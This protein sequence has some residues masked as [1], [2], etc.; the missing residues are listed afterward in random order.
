[1]KI[2]SMND[3]AREVFIL[4]IAVVGG[5]SCCP[6]VRA[7]ARRLGRLLAEKGHVVL[8]G[9][10]GGVME[11][12]CCGAKEAG[13]MTV[14]ILPGEKENANRCVDIAI[15]T[16]MGHARNVVIVKSADVIIALPGEHGTLSEIA[17]ALKMGKPVVSLRSW[18]IPGT[19][20]AETPEEA[21]ALLG[22][23]ASWSRS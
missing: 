12:V 22:L 17:L 6:E 10:L 19:L 23:Q 21:L 18:E 3:P 1:M 16:G 7:E 14:G 2:T 15:A 13:G 8:C 11:A 9:G 4:Q 20:K 5:G